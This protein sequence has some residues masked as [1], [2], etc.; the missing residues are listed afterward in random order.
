[1]PCYNTTSYGMEGL[2]SINTFAPLIFVVAIS[3]IILGLVIYSLGSIKRFK[4]IWKLLDFL[5]KSFMYF[6]YGCLTLIVVV[7]P[8]I[9]IYWLGQTT[10]EGDT[11]PLKWICYILGSYFGIAGLGYLVKKFI[12]DKFQKYSKKLEKEGKK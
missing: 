10:V 5:G 12:V 1:M 2:A 11:V 8:S 4:K 6:G 7:L 9:F 3:A